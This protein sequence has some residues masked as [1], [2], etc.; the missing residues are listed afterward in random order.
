MDNIYFKV[1]N[2]TDRAFEYDLNVALLISSRIFSKDNM[3][4]SDAWRIWRNDENPINI[5]CSVVRQTKERCTRGIWDENGELRGMKLD[6][7]ASFIAS[8]IVAEWFYEFSAI[9]LPLK[10]FVRSRMAELVK[11]SS[12]LHALVIRCYVYLLITISPDTLN[13][14]LTA[15]RAWRYDENYS[16]TF[17]LILP[18]FAPKF[19]WF[20]PYFC[21]FSHTFNYRR[22][23]A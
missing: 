19:D 13:R 10:L 9:N 18:D 5:I 12:V 21:L 16:N 22:Q 1:T 4:S 6:I 3:L 14:W 7:L 17:F 23:W 8:S 15:R 20:L 2:E 11:W